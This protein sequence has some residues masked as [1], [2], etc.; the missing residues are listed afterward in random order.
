MFLP[1]FPLKLVVYPNEKT[2][3][4]VFEER[5]KELVNDCEKNGSAFGIPVFMNGKVHAYGCELKIEAIKKRYEDG[6][7]LNVQV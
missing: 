1:I 5:Y 7:L 2:N 4:H 6:K 3:L